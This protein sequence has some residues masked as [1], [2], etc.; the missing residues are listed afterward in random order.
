MRHRIV[1]LIV[2]ALLLAV[3]VGAAAVAWRVERNGP[4]VAAAQR[5]V[6]RRI[7][8]LAG[9]VVDIS[10]AQAAYVAPG[11]DPAPALERFPRL[12]R[13]VSTGTAEI[14]LT[15]RAAP[16]RPALQR[17]ADATSR[18]AQADALARDSLLLGDTLT[19]SHVIF[20]ESR[21]ALAA[22]STSLGTLRTVETSARA[23]ERAAEVTRAWMIV[24]GAGLVWAVGLLLVALLSL[25]RPSARGNVPLPVDEGI[26]KN[27]SPASSM[28]HASDLNEAA[29]LCTALSRVD[30]TTAL[31][32]LLARAATL[33]DG[34]GIVVW[35]SAGEELFAAAVHGY[36]A[37]MISRLGAIPRDALNATAAAWR[38][39]TVQLVP[40][41]AT[42]H[43][44]IAAPLLGPDSCL[45]V[46]AVELRHG[47]E[48]DEATRAITLMIAAQLASVVA[49]WP[50]VT[51][52]ANEATGT[53]SEAHSN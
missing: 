28:L 27:D 18:L 14:G 50:A 38:T 1:R 43:G 44:A 39:G 35:M 17:F 11:Q 5:D 33:L 3:G 15:L 4:L 49:G 40:G 52:V 21:T 30:T 29:D 13:Q 34:A 41:D 48:A 16:S 19:A 42:S 24:A 22:M 12:L 23:D 25:Q 51:P 31:P 9:A 2:V 8:V 26:A 20:G 37:A 47:R 7:D 10:A 32:S 53:Y 36:T 46:F 6:D 45:G